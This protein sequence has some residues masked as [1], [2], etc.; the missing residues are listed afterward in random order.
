MVRCGVNLAFYLHFAKNIA[1]SYDA[2]KKTLTIALF[3]VN[4]AAQY[5]NME[6]DTKKTTFQW[7]C[8]E[9]IQ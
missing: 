8:S 2:D 3:D 4:A 5:L 7:R 9:C 6:W 1:G